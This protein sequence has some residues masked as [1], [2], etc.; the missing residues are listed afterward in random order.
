MK[1]SRIQ[2][3]KLSAITWLVILMSLSAGSGCTGPRPPRVVVISSDQT[4]ERVRAGE[5]FT[6]S[7]DG[8]FMSDALYQ[9]TRRAIADR[10]LE[11]Q[12]DK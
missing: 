1:K 2:L 6:P 11:L 12:T 5:A 10:I 9:R 8:W 4:I 3:R 7:V